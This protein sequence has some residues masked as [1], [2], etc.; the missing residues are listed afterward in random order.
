LL[1]KTT[2]IADL[3]KGMV[4]IKGHVRAKQTISSLDK[5]A[6]YYKAIDE[7]YESGKYS[8]WKKKGKREELLPFEVEDDSGTMTISNERTSVDIKEDN[9]TGSNEEMDGR[10]RTRHFYL[11][12]GSPVYVIGYLR[13]ENGKRYIG[14][15]FGFPFIISDHKESFLASKHGCLGFGLVAVVVLAAV[16]FLG[17]AHDHWMETW[18]GCVVKKNIRRVKTRNSYRDCYEIYLGNLEEETK[19]TIPKQEWERVK[20]G[21]TTWAGRLI[22]KKNTISRDKSIDY[23]VYLSH[24][25][26]KTKEISSQLWKRVKIGDYVVKNSRSYNIEIHQ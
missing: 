19:K 17:L 18:G 16:S 21:R 14:K 10:M 7:K 5:P 4:E 26:K 3:K 2:S 6:V 22:V 11:E 12:G 23:V 1:T 9:I 8:G 25:V 20:V 15:K 24:R 13:D